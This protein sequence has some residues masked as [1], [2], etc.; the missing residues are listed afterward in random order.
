[1]CNEKLGKALGIFGSSQTLAQLFF[2][3]RFEDLFLPSSLDL[4]YQS[5]SAE[6]PYWGSIRVFVITYSNYLQTC[7]HRSC[8]S[9]CRQDLADNVLASANHSNPSVCLSPKHQSAGCFWGDFPSLCSHQFKLI[10]N[11]TFNHSCDL[12]KANSF[13]TPLTNTHSRLCVLNFGSYW[14]THS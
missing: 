2:Q 4:R 5:T 7:R 3:K 8:K 12:T 11:A 9:L 6:F 1:M 13:S 10:K 14:I